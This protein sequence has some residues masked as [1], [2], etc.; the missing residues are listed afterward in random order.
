MTLFDVVVTVV[1]GA[2]TTDAV[3]VV[4]VADVTGD[5]K[6]FSEFV[7]TESTLS[8]VQ[9][10]SGGAAA[11]DDTVTEGS[12]AA[13]RIRATHHHAAA[14]AVMP[15]LL[16]LFGRLHG[17]IKRLTKFFI[18]LFVCP[19][20]WHSKYRWLLSVTYI[21]KDPM[22]RPCSSYIVCCIFL[23]KYKRRRKNG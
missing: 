7:R 20:P 3:V 11:A 15:S 13:S 14:A 6:A 21:Y 12:R 8:I 17:V 10:K 5:S 18:S 4:V 2:A 1:T 16:L 19:S 22:R 9:S 23:E